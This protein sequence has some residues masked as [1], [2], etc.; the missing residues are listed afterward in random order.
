[1]A[2]PSYWADRELAIEWFQTVPF[3]MNPEGMAA[4]CYQGDGLKLWEET[5]APFNI[6]APAGTGVCPTD[7]RM[8]PQEDQHAQRLQ[9]AQDARGPPTGGRA[10]RESTS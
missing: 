6:V 7:G 1:M 10:S 3:G 2:A 5:Y 9:R 4:W 8:V